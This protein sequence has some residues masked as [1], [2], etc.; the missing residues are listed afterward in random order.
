MPLSAF[1]A[2]ED[3]QRLTADGNYT[4]AL[5]MTDQELENNNGDITY[6]FLKGLILTRMNDLEQARDV[7]IEK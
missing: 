4:E 1:S 7:F 6:R 5:A 3:I 2:I